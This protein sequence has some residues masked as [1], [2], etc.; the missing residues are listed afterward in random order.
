METVTDLIFLGSKI[1]ADCDC[2]H[3]I[4]RCL[5]LGRKAMTN[6]DS[7]LKSKDIT[8][9]TKVCIVMVF[10]VITYGCEHWNIKKA[11]KNLCFRTLVLEKTLESPVDSKEIKPVN[12]KG[13]QPWIFIG[14]TDAEAE[15]PVLWPTNAKSQLTGKDADPGE[16]LKAKREEGGRG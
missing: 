6:L 3:E 11:P 15:A 16:R 2:S 9:P 13:N 10:L 5:F 4:I 7:V 8:L 1:T 14:R 12:H